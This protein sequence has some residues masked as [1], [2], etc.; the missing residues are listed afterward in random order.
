MAH[1]FDMHLLIRAVRTGNGWPDGNHIHIRVRFLEQTALQTRVDH[2][3]V[4]RAVEQ[5]LISFTHQRHHR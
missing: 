5:T 3:N 1:A 2:L 4:R